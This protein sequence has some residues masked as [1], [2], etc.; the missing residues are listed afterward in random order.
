MMDWDYVVIA[1]C[2]FSVPDRNEPSGYSDCGDPATYRI[3]WDDGGRDWYDC[4]RHLPIM[5][6]GK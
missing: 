3:M 6:E 1:N 5:K 2:M 4:E